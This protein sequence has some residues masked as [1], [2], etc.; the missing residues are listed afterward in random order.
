MSAV[1]IHIGFSFLT[2]GIV[3]KELFDIDMYTGIVVVAALTGI[4][5]IIG[6]LMAVVVTEAI[7][8]VVLVL[9]AAVITYFAWDKIGG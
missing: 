1:T 8:T 6:G 9:G 2:G 5:T 3:L 7:Q 4:Y